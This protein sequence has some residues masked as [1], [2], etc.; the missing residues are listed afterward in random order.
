MSRCAS[1]RLYSRFRSDGS[2]ARALYRALLTAFPQE[3]EFCPRLSPPKRD[4]EIIIIIIPKTGDVY[5]IKKE[6]S[7]GSKQ[8]LSL[9]LTHLQVVAQ[10]GVTTR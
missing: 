3:Q 4:N 1:G 10:I 9:G 5:H 8:L 6:Q 2:Q 7:G